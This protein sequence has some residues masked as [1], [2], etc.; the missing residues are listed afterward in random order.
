MSFLIFLDF[1]GG[2]LCSAKRTDVASQM[3]AILMFTR[4]NPHLGMN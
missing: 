3:F 4:M 1:H 2:E